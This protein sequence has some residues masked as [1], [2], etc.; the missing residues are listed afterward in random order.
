MPETPQRD[1]E[2][3]VVLPRT[4]LLSAS[5]RAFFERLALR[6]DAQARDRERFLLEWAEAAVHRPATLQSDVPAAVIERAIRD[7]ACLSGKHVEFRVRFAPHVLGRD[8]RGRHVVLAFEYGGLTLG[9]AHWVCF[10]LHRLRGLRRTG[11]PWRTASME[12][13]PQFAL[14]E[15]EAAVDDSWS[16]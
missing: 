15:I 7:R 8:E 2:Q 11:D 12:R 16:R 5:D 4:A 13:R 14:T 1:R 10:E 9:R 3:A 6:L